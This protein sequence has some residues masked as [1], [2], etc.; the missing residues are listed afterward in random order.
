MTLLPGLQVNESAFN[1]VLDTVV[2]MDVVFAVR[3]ATKTK[4]AEMDTTTCDLPKQ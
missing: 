4:P 2:D 1:H 3:I